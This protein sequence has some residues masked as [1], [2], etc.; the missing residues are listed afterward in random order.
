MQPEMRSE[1]RAGRVWSLRPLALRD[2]AA[3]LRINAANTPGVALIDA[4]ELALLLRFEGLHWVAVDGRDAVL[5]YLLSFPSASA[6]DDEEL[7]HFRR[8]VP[9]PFHYVAQV[10]VDAA[11]RGRGIGRRLHETVAR[12]VR[13]RGVRTVCADVNVDPPNQASLD[14]HCRLGFVPVGRAAL[15][16]GGAIALLVSTA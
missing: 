8:L 7:R 3:L 2:H 14:F 10:A 6:Y 9:V 16:S 4:N 13:R 15:S 12:Q 11:H 1:S 5:A